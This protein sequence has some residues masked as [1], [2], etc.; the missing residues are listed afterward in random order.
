MVW[1]DI[2]D[3]HIWILSTH[4]GVYLISIGQAI[5]NQTQE[6]PV[7]VSVSLRLVA[8]PPICCRPPLDAVLSSGL[9][10]KE[11]A[12]FLATGLP[13]QRKT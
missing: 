10:G 8:I 13:V 12:L 7:F 9:C 1:K 2:E 11:A 6:C 5:L 3:V 4:V